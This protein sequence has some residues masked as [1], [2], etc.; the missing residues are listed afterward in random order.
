MKTYYGLAFAPTIS[1]LEPNLAC[2]SLN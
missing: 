1:T 2:L